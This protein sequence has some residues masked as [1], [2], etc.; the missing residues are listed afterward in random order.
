[1]PRETT[2]EIESANKTLNEAFECFLKHDFPI[3]EK[4]CDLKWEINK[5]NEF[6]DVFEE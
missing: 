6:K 1:M 2:L 4:G 5:N 3:Y